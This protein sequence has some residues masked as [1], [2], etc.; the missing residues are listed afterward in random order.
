MAMRR[1]FRSGVDVLYA[2]R[3]ICA[4]RRCLNLCSAMEHRGGNVRYEVLKLYAAFVE[5][6]RWRGT[7]D[8]VAMRR[9]QLA[10]TYAAFG[11]I[12]E[13]CMVLEGI[14]CA[15]PRPEQSPDDQLLT[16]EGYHSI[17]PSPGNTC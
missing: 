5:P 3:L 16:L 9:V 13:R 15:E 7:I 2:L 17:S 10:Q 4:G 11:T 12:R 14:V 1:R 6:Y 8:A